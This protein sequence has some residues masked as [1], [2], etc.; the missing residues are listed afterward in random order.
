MIESQ[1]IILQVKKLKSKGMRGHLEDPMAR[2]GS[3]KEHS[4]FPSPSM[5]LTLKAAA[6]FNNLL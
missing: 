1:V 6:Y 5:T 3:Y 2:Y 4:G